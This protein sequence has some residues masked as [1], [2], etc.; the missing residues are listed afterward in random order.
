M[1]A[2]IKLLIG[3][4]FFV[5]G[6]LWFFFDLVQLPPALTIL[7]FST[8]TYPRFVERNFA[9]FWGLEFLLSFALAATGLLL[10][11]SWSTG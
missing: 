3:I 7:G 1:R 9:A 4:I 11:F 8:H 2:I 5:L 6:C 10:I